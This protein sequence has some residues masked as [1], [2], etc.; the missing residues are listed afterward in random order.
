MVGFITGSNRIDRAEHPSFDLMGRQRRGN[1]R[2]FNIPI[3]MIGGTRREGF[4]AAFG[5]ID[6]LFHCAALVFHH[7]HA[8]VCLIFGQVGIGNFGISHVDLSTR[9]TPLEGNPGHT[10]HVL[11]HI[12]DKNARPGLVNTLRWQRSE[13]S[14]GLPHLRHEFEIGIVIG[15]GPGKKATRLCMAD[16]AFEGNLHGVFPCMVI[17]CSGRPTLNGR[18]LQCIVHLALEERTQSDGAIGGVSPGIGRRNDA[19]CGAVGIGNDGLYQH[20]LAVTVEVP[21]LSGKRTCATPPTFVEHDAERILPFCEQRGDVIGLIE[22]RFVV[23]C[24]PRIE[25]IP[26]QKCAVDIA[27]ID[28]SRRDIE[29]SMG[30]GLVVECETRAQ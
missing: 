23:L 21:V 5:N 3:A 6:V 18:F 11:P 13:V 4:C 22:Q 14:N 1:A 26:A 20:R 10:G 7:H 19:C 16:G 15:R 29:A 28:A 17:E 9:C 12:V 2:D 30:N 8:H 24:A 25:I 27:I